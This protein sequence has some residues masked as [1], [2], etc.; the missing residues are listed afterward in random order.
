MTFVSTILYRVTEASY[1]ASVICPPVAA[2]GVEFS[3]SFAYMGGTNTGVTYKYGDLDPV[4]VPPEKRKCSS[5]ERP[6]Y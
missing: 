5:P 6:F 2:P 3:C 4:D 1:P